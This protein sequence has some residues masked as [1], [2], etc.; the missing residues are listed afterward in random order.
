MT[1]VSEVYPIQSDESDFQNSIKVRVKNP[2]EANFVIVS[3]L[4]VIVFL[5]QKQIG[6]LDFISS[7]YD[8]VQ[9]FLAQLWNSMK[10]INE[11]LV[12]YLPEQFLLAVLKTLCGILHLVKTI[13][14]GRLNVTRTVAL[15][16]QIIA[17]ILSVEPLQLAADLEKALCFCLFDLATLFE[18]PRSSSEVFDETLISVLCEITNHDHRI[19]ALSIDL[20]VRTIFSNSAGC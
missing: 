8:W 12:G 14:S 13:K 20:Q 7:E 5:D 2:S 3:L 1:T 15:L 4:S 6:N 19:S 17:D 10:P 18:N 11:P 16:S 9:G